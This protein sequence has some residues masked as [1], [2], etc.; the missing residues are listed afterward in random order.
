MIGTWVSG[1]WKLI[2]LAQYGVP[3]YRTREYKMGK[4][5]ELRNGS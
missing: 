5:Y 2:D 4:K 1:K 3:A